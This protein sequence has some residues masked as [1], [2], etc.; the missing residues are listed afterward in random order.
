MFSFL[1]ESLYFA[2]QP[3]SF[4]CRSSTIFHSTMPSRKKAKGQARKAKREIENCNKQNNLPDYWDGCS[5]FDCKRKW[6]QD[7]FDVAHGTVLKC[8]DAIQALIA[9]FK[10]RYELVLYE[11][12]TEVYDRH[13]SKFSE[14]R[15]DIFWRIILASGTAAC[16]KAGKEK[17]L[18]KKTEILGVLPLVAMIKTIEVRDSHNGAWNMKIRGDIITQINDAGSPRET[19]RLFHRRNS[20]DCLKELYYKL[21][22][23]T[24]RTSPCWNCQRRVDIRMISQCQCKVANYCSYDCAVANWLEHK[25]SCKQWRISNEPFYGIEKVD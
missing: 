8:L 16:I 5:H 25:A 2:N 7:D 13:Y 24:K 4:S 1:H 19:V 20:C 17:D 11:L 15:K 14:E 23:N 12:V 18:T 9:Q 10:N 21:K 3:A 22:E 6:P